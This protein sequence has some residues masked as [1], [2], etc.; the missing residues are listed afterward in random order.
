MFV[1]GN[2]T[3]WKILDITVFRHYWH[4]WLWRILPVSFY[5][6][7]VLR[8]GSPPPQLL[9]PVVE[10]FT[11]NLPRNATEGQLRNLFSFFEFYRFHDFNSF[12][13]RVKNFME[14]WLVKGPLE[15]GYL[16]RIALR[17]PDNCGTVGTMFQVALDPPHPNAR[18]VHEI[19]LCMILG[20]ILDKIEECVDQTP[21]DDIDVQDAVEVFL[22]IGGEYTIETINEI[23]GR[24][25]LNEEQ[26]DNV[27]TAYAYLDFIFKKLDNRFSE[28][29]RP[30][31]TNLGV[32]MRRQD[33]LK[34]AGY[35]NDTKEKS[36]CPRM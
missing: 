29:A 15:Y 3:H 9:I 17:D 25:D 12:I 2:A 11:I 28:K 18:Q 23:I 13:S 6:G 5:A 31:M 33:L 1:A 26:V 22:G 36:A 8:G 20:G 34:V 27:R 21:M 30:G 16:T 32:Y 19:M 4:W 10:Y 7:V 24:I 14:A 35:T